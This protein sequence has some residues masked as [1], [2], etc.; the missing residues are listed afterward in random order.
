MSEIAKTGAWVA[1]RSR[2]FTRYQIAKFLSTLATQM[3][4]VA[5]GWQV[6]A[7]T[8]RYLDLGY[9]GLAQFLPQV[10]LSLVTG[11]VADRVDR[12]KIVVICYAV[13]ALGWALLG[14]LSLGGLRD[15]RLVYAVLVLLG[16][17]RSFAG[18]ANSA[19]V[20]NLVPVEH[21]ANAVAWGS[22]TW[23][24]ATIAGPTLGGL[25]YDA[26][27]NPAVV[28][29]CATAMCLAAL[30]LCVTLAPRAVA[31]TRRESTWEALLGGVRYVWREKVVLGAISLDLFAVLLGGAVA[32]LPV[33][34]ND[35]LHADARGLGLLRGAPAAGAA[36][37]AVLL[38]YRPLERHAGRWMF[39]SVAV[40]G[41]ATVVFALSTATWLSVLALAVVGASDMVSV[42]VRQHA[43]QVATPDAMRGRVSAVNLIFVG[44]S[45]ELGEFESGLTAEWLGPVRAVALGGV[46]TLAVV[47]LWALF[48]PALRRLD[49]LSDLQREK[50]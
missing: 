30:T 14:A 7:T 6:Y 44:A 21:L 29:G 37:M 33:F 36:L 35:I 10:L 17:A 23:Q 32:L 41:A 12:R 8:H 5:I 3:G 47:T 15:V 48:F 39:A 27:S 50:V 24:V 4:A 11:A 26:A 13:T 46:G 34:A 28:Y 42:I 9:V 38:A 31:S 19:L 1:F 49:R 20:P 18:P 40:F 22:T 2:E 16:V 25:V 43:V 45:N